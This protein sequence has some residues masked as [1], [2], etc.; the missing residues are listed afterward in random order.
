M[1]ELVGSFISKAKLDAVATAALSACDGHGIDDVADG[2]LAD[3]RACTFSAAEN[4]CG[5]PSAP[6]ADCLSPEEAAAVDLIWDGPRNAFGLR[7]YPGDAKGTL[8]DLAETELTDK[9]VLGAMQWNHQD[10][11]FD[12]RTVPLSGYGAEIELA[13]KLYGDIYDGRSPALEPVRDGNKKILMWHG[14]ADASITFENS[15][16]YYVRVAGYFGGGNPDFVGLQP[17]FR[18]VLAPGVAHCGGGSGPQPVGLLDAVVNWVE[19]EIPPDS[20]TAAKPGMTRPLCLF[21]KAAR[22]NGFGDPNVASS[23]ECAGDLQT[24]EAIEKGR[25]VPYQ[26]E[27]ENLLETYGGGSV[28]TP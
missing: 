18:Y 21:P 26:R 9:T 5:A 17:W 1:N 27:S 13:A 3:P 25:Y 8:L 10:L 6:L 4:V 11:F 7:I 23:F 22:W 15:L 24:P 20:L 12:W 14:T 28:V 2:F 16:N 19:K